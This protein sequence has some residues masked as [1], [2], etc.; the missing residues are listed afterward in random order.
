M[1]LHHC[2]PLLGVV[3]CSLAPRADADII[4]TVGPVAEY[5]TVSAAVSAADADTNLNHYYTIDVAPGTYVNDFP[6][7]TRAMTITVNPGASG[8]S[9]VLEATEPLPN[10][11]GILLSTASLT[12]NGLIFEGAEIAN[13]LGGNGAGIRD[14]NTGNPASLVVLDSSFIGNQEG[15]LTGDDA[16]EKIQVSFSNFAN[17]GNPDP[18]YFQHALYVNDAGSLTVNNDV[19]CGQLIGHDIKS[20][21]AMTTVRKN[22]IYDGAADP[23]GGCSGAGST[24]FG[25]DIA[26]GGVASVTGNRIVQGPATEN[27][28]MIDYGEEGLLYGAN[29]ISLSSNAFINTAP[30]GTALYDPQCVPAQLTSNTF[31]GITT[32]IDPAGCVAGGASLAAFAAV[33][34]ADDPPPVPEPRGLALLLTALAGWAGAS[35]LARIGRSRRLQAA[36]IARRARRRRP[37]ADQRSAR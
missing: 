35:Q 3:L 29:S 28:K 11:K 25:I 14:Q 8:Q 1:R 9:A 30:F 34:G 36:P 20:R 2:L 15:I 22:Q 16:N 17:N 21:A 18:N 26:N 12:V 33:S 37:A 24:S 31:Q 10:E 13:S 6:D 7:V 19:F 4:L 23:A 5:R 27:F 32:E